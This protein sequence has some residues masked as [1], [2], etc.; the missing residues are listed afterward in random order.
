M[1]TGLG[2]DFHIQTIS[3]MLRICKEIRITPIV[4]LNGNPSEL[5]EKIIE[6]F[7][8]THNVEQMTSSYEFLKNG[9]KML[10]IKNSM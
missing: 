5:T 1:Y 4:D 10:C 8:K 9:N 2:Y 6:Y 3:E 7:M